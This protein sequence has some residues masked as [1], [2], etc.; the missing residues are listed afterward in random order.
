MLV[1]E[2]QSL[3]AVNGDQ[4]N[5]ADQVQQ[6]ID[7]GTNFLLVLPATDDSISNFCKLFGY[8]D[9]CSPKPLSRGEFFLLSQFVDGDNFDEILRAWDD[10]HQVVYVEQIDFP[11]NRPPR[12]TEYIV[13]SPVFGIISQNDD[14]REARTALS[15]YENTEHYHPA[16]RRAAIYHWEGDRWSMVE[17]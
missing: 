5:W 12:L 1:K 13:Y 7:S 8:E 2:V 11:V 4:E 10:D 17:D 16:T 6:H 14:L 15:G 9:G 3:R